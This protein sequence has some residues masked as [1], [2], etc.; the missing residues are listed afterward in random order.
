MPPP[1][2]PVL[3]ALVVAAVALGTRG[4]LMSRS[5]APSFGPRA[6][7]RYLED[8]PDPGREAADAARTRSRARPGTLPAGPPASAAASASAPPDAGPA[9]TPK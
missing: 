6:P 3:I 9:P 1:R 5:G 2:P 8:E 7:A 4:V